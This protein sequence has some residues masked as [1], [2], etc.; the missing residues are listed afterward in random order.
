[1]PSIEARLKDLLDETRLMML[2]TQLLMGLQY[3]AAFAQKFGSLPLAYRWLDG[4]ALLFILITAALLLAVPSYHQIADHGHA[5]GRMLRRTSAHLKMALLPLSLTLGADVSIAYI[6]TAGPW[7]APLGGASFV[8]AALFVWYGLPLR[9]ATRERE[10]AMEDKEQSLEIR[11]EQALTELRVVLPGAQ[12][13]FGFQFAAV[14]TATFSHLPVVLKSIHLA[15]LGVVAMAV[16]M[17]IAPAAYHRIASA[18]KADERVLRYA[19]RM[20][21]PAQGLIA[22]G[23]IGEA[24]I[25]TRIVFASQF[26]AISIAAI[27]SVMFATLLYVMP[28][29]DRR[30]SSPH[31]RGVRE[32]PE[33]RRS[34][35]LE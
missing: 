8:I 5:T 18:G 12:A 23:L 4:F 24:Y 9:A 10:D 34:R 26:L 6:E 21:L 20:M 33:R 29:L 11:I 7:L 13:L 35:P 32:A 1:M 28:L 30:I 22:V 14:L 16:M 31:F 15:G 17:L 2:G 3:N 27:A 25:T 19:I